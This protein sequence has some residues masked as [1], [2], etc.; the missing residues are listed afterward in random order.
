MYKGLEGFIRAH[1]TSA[2]I[3]EAAEKLGINE[4]AYRKRFSVYNYRLKKSGYEPLVRH[5]GK[6]TRTAKALEK[7]ALEGLINKSEEN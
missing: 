5:D 4:A 6:D 7:L 2:T 1:Q 3:V